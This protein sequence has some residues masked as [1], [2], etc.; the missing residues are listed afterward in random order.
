MNLKRRLERRVEPGVSAPSSAGTLAAP[1]LQ[2]TLADLRRQLHT[3]L[4]RS[5]SEGFALPP[6]RAVRRR[7]GETLP[8]IAR[9][10]TSGDFWQRVARLDPSHRVGRM[11]LETVALADTA[12]LAELALDPAVAR[13]SVSSWLFLDLETTGFAGAGTLA[14]LVGMAGVDGDGSIVVEQLLLRDPSSEPALLER[15]AERIA[16]ASLIISFNGKAFDRPLLDGRY[17]MNRLAPPPERPHLDLLHVGRRLHARRLQRCTLGRVERGVLGFD[18]G[19]DVDGSDMPAI[20]AHFLRSSDETAMASVVR[21]NFSDVV[22]MVALA[23]LYGQRSPPL[24]GQDLA[25]LARTLQRAGATRYAE[26]VADAACERGGGPDALRVRAALCKSRGDAL[27][28]IRDLERL[29]RE[30]DDP[31]G[32]LE[33]AKLYE[34]GA[35]RPACALRW[36][37]Q[38][39]SEDAAAHRR[40]LERLERK[41]RRNP[42]A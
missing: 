30:A 27:G 25:S 4:E 40:R 33:L 36:A 20:Y 26:S 15:V 11:T 2:H 6:L 22:S 1:D 23:A 32:R 8:F 31:V 16:A 37:E 13:S 29:C 21:H 28:A 12:A 35:R 41:I 19:D 34:H 10:G 3:M 17:V 14:F 18:R 9:A 7:A 39:T 42:V 24:A 38:G 5:P